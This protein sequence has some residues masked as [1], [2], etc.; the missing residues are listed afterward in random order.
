M[1][2]PRGEVDF[3]SML[4]TTLGEMCA[5]SDQQCGLLESHFEV[6]MRWNRRMNLTAVRDPLEAIKRHYCE[7][8]FLAMHL[9][10]EALTVV[11]VGSGA[12]FPGIGVAVMRP[13]ATVALVESSQKKAAFLKESTRGFS[14]VRVLGRRAEELGE[15]FDWLVSRAVAW[16]DLPLLADHIA[17]LA[18]E[19]GPEFAWSKKIRLPWGDRRIL[20]IGDVAGGIAT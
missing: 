20:L 15:R 10:E 4:R 3:A 16:K 13:L 5:V 14:N 1:T 9:P 2:E 8:V 17:L 7:S 11:D 18:A 6:L 12:G 19:P